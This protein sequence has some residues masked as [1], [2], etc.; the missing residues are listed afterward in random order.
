MCLG[1]SL[2]CV[3]TC[4]NKFMGLS[5]CT[6]LG[7]HSQHILNH[8]LLI[9]LSLGQYLVIGRLV[10]MSFILVLSTTCLG[11]EVKVMRWRIPFMLLG[12]LTLGWDEIWESSVEQSL[13][14]IWVYVG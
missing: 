5:L 13:I 6:L 9:E 8:L 10:R 14:K 1:K 11:A 4:L 12:L 3:C 7:L 2:S